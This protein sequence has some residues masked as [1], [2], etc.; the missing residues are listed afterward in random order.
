MGNNR[1]S[2]PCRR[3]GRDLDLG[4]WSSETELCDI[5]AIELD[6]ELPPPDSFSDKMPKPEDSPEPFRPCP[7]ESEEEKH[8]RKRKEDHDHVWHDPLKGLR[9]KHHDP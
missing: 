1:W 9:P 4:L 2:K 8:S 3:C 7:T 6:L 5:C